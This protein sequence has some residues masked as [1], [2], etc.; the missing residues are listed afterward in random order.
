MKTR[1]GVNIDHIAT[2]RQARREFDPDPLLAVKIAEKAGADGIVAHLR[3]DRRHI[4]DRDIKAIKRLVKTHFNLEMSLNPQIIRIACTVRPDMATLVP[5]RRQ[6]I[7]TE[8]GLDVIRHFSRIQQAVKK[9]QSRGI[10]VSLF[11]DP[12]R[13]QI[14]KAKESGATVIEL[15]TGKYAHGSNKTKKH[16]ELKKLKTM[17]AYGRSLGLSVSAGHGLKYHDTKPVAKLKDIE[18]LNIGHS[19]ISRAV[20]T[21]LESAIREMRAIIRSV[22]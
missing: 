18:E 12:E 20:F 11:I 16:A 17:A 3:E 15:H 14:L 22:K 4:N 19:I 10:V 8:G 2:L 9:L 13:T 5:E 7:T 21:G 6:E 1:L